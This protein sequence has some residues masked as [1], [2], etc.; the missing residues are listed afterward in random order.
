MTIG[1]LPIVSSPRTGQYKVVYVHDN[2]TV[3]ISEKATCSKKS[4]IQNNTT[5]YKRDKDYKQL[6]R[7]A[8]AV[9]W[10]YLVEILD[11]LPLRYHK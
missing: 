9:Y 6:H 11:I 3:T 8:N 7:E 1:I 5:V 2:G 4:N 10:E